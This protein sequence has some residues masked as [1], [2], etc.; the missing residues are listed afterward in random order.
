MEEWRS[1]HGETGGRRVFAV[2]CDQSP[3][4]RLIISPRPRKFDRS[5]AQAAFDLGA[6]SFEVLTR[7]KLAYLKPALMGSGLISFFM[8]LETFN[9]TLKLVGSDPPLTITMFDRL[10]AGSTPQLNAVLQ[11]LMLASAL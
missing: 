2:D 11:F 6:S 7:I 4:T 8:S 1:D 5:L 10:K 9:T 3:V